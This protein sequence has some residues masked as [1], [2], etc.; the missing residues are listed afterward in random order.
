MRT[1][2]LLLLVLVGSLGVGLG[3]RVM[4]TAGVAKPPAAAKAAVY[5]NGVPQGH[6]YTGCSEEPDDVNPFTSH[7]QVARRLVLGYTHEGLLDVDPAT[8][9]LR[10]SLA[11]KFELAADGSVCD[12]TLREGVR[13]ADGAPVTLD[14]VLFGWDLAAAGHLALGF[15]ADT[16]AR[17]R[18]V[19]RLDDRSFRLHFRDR[20]Y[21]M[22]RVVGET[23]LVAQKK[24]FVDRVAARCHPQPAP[25]VASAEFATWLSQIRTECG[26]GTGPYQLQN[27]PNGPL[28]WHSRKDLLLV[29]NEH[30][31]RRLAAPGTWN[32]AGIR[33]LWRDQAGATNALL[34]GEVDWFSSQMLSELLQARPELAKNA[35]R[36][37]YDYEMLGVFRTVWKCTD[38]PCADVRVRRALGMLFDIDSILQGCEG[39]AVRAFAHAKVGSK[40]YPTDVTPLRFD[41]AQARSLLRE[42]G[43]D[44]EQGK[45]LRLVVVALQGTDVLRRIADLFADAASKAGIQLDL[46]RRDYAAYMQ[47]KKVDDW[48]GVVV[49]QLFRPSGDPFDFVH[50]KG[51]DNEGHWA[52]A[53]VD[54][55]AT[56][57]REEFDEERRGALWREMHAIVY[58]E[59][60]V[61]FLM[62]PLAS[63]LLDRRIEGAV[64]GRTGLV[65]ERAFVAPDRQR[66]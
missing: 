46:R 66:Q 1:L 58:R 32:F 22:L 47:E 63:V 3:L 10:P 61:A 30:S 57:A 6:V 20:H 39:T 44:P 62:H 52:N 43:Y 4:G 11:A 21:A 17:V 36:L 7:N 31:W 23:W 50:S 25:A 49:Q 51:V 14:D 35:T 5:R 16:Y 9:E 38:G 27:D 33:L 40:A 15:V 29:P 65:V 64:P 37:V 34:R 19:E 41:V 54:R 55:L 59:Q 45:P 2:P 26:P 18:A 13:F 60:P 53:E 48:H 12:F 24:F 56:A 8:G 28:A 42:A